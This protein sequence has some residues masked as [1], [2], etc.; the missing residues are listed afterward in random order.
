MNIY[1]LFI[2]F[3]YIIILL[4]FIKLMKK[5]N[6]SLYCDLCLNYDNPNNTDLEKF[7]L[8]SEL[9]VSAICDSFHIFAVNVF[10]KGIINNN[11]VII[12]TN[13]INNYNQ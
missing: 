5:T 8:F 6:T 11:D 10:K 1:M 2:L 3:Y 7:K 13:N 4:Y 9:I 12:I